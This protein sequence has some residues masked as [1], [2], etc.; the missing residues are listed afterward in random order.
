MPLRDAPEAIR[1]SRRQHEVL[2]LAVGLGLL[3]AC[4][5]RP[6]EPLVLAREIPLQE[7]APDRVTLGALR[8]EAGFQLGADDPRFGGLSGLWLAPDGHELMAV[9]DRGTLWRATLQH[10]GDRLAGFADWQAAALASAA[11]DPGGR[12]DAEALA[13]DGA[14]DLIVAIE[15]PLP[16]RRIA[17]DDPGAPPEPLPAAVQLSETGARAGNAGIEALTALPDGRLLALSE[18]IVEGPGELAAWQIADGQVTPLR[19]VTSDGFVPTGADWLDDTIYIVERRFSLLDGGFASRLVAL[20]V[21]QVRQDEPL[22]PHTLAQLGRPAISENF[23]GIAARRG[24]DGRILLYLVSD[25]NFL[26]LQRT[27]LLQFS[28]AG[29]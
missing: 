24:A 29:P 21:E 17:R 25:D 4:Q 3:C 18:G 13:D 10:D 22:R 1:M 19:Y 6:N 9:S 8:F 28:L 16:L 11:G 12:I 5:A 2:C 7:D 27:L 14:G 23:E 26:P 20:D 15:G